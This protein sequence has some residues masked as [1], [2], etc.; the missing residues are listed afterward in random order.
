MPGASGSPCLHGTPAQAGNAYFTIIKLCGGFYNSKKQN[1]F[2][3]TDKKSQ[4]LHKTKIKSRNVPRTLFFKVRCRPKAA[5]KRMSFAR[6]R[7]LEHENQLLQFASWQKPSPLGDRFPPA[8]GSH[9]LEN[10]FYGLGKQK[11]LCRNG[12]RAGC[13]TS[14]AAFRRR[15]LRLPRIRRRRSRSCRHRKA[16]PAWGRWGTWPAQADDALRQPRP[17]GCCQTH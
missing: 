11:A 14:S 7:A 13:I 10:R 3:K 5:R 16:P 2:K 9:Q 12:H 1:L 17:H 8:G 4:L 6:R 15:L